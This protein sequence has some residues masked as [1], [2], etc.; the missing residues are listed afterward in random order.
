MCSLLSSVWGQYCGELGVAYLTQKDQQHNQAD[1]FIL[2]I[3]GCRICNVTEPPADK[4]INSAVMKN[5]TGG[6]A[7]SGRMLHSNTLV[8]FKPQLKLHIWCNIKP[9]IDGCDGGVARR[10]KVIE[11]VSKFV[12]SKEELKGEYRYLAD[13]T[14]EDKFKEDTFKLDMFHYLLENFD[15]FENYKYTEPEKIKLDSSSY[16]ENY[17]DI[18]RFI[19]ENLTKCIMKDCPLCKINDKGK[20]PQSDIVEAN[21]YITYTECKEAYQK[22]GQDYRCDKNRM[23]R[24][25]GDLEVEL[26]IKFSE[27]SWGKKNVRNALG[28]WQLKKH[29]EEDDYGNIRKP[30]QQKH[31]KCFEGYEEDEEPEEPEQPKCK[32][33]VNT[34]NNGYYNALNMGINKVPY[35][36]TINQRGDQPS[37][38]QDCGKCK[39]RKGDSDSDSD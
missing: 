7:L 10:A 12:K 21:H 18:F 32:I 35:G 20:L 4:Q 29:L 28:G 39:F 38:S 24:F 1:P 25:K 31:I 5:L 26:G 15:D 36:S 16:I 19:K 34:F 3:K 14:L 8:R 13:F 27:K 37:T 2:S 33:K 30:E 23:K 9:V 6:D 22:K 17:N 11:Y